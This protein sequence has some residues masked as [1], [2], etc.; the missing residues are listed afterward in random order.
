MFKGKVKHYANSKVKTC[1]K[2]GASKR[3][4][5]KTYGVA[6]THQKLMKYFL[7]D[8]CDHK[9]LRKADTA[10]CL[11]P[12]FRQGKS[13]GGMRLLTDLQKSNEGL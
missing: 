10:E 1:F 2:E 12:V 8:S 3:H 11:I 9:V 4:E 7:E 6:E 5:F 13:G